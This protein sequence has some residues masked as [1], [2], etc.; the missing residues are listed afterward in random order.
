[1]A[2]RFKPVTALPAGN[3][4]VPSG[5]QFVSL[6]QT[7][8]N[9]AMDGILVI[10]KPQGMSSHD[11][12]GSLRRKYGQK[13]FG[14]CGT[15]DPMASGVLVV[16]AGKAA[17]A[18]Q[19]I[20]DTDKEYTAG[21][22]L[23]KKYDTDDI[24][25]SLLEEKTVKNDFDFEAVLS[26]FQGQLHQ[27]VPD[28]SAK[29]VNGKK[30]YEYLREGKQVPAVYSD[31]EIYSIE[32]LENSG[33]NS[34]GQ[35]PENAHEYKFHVHCSSGTYI[36]ALCRDFGEKTG[37]LAAMSSLCRTKANGFSIEQAE[38]LDAP[39]HT[40]YPLAAVIDLPRLQAE[41]PDDIRNGKHIRLDT[42]YDRVLIMEKD[43][44]LAVYDRHHGN[45]FSCTRGLW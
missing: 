30:L 41:N 23:G 10:N 5:L 14:H 4:T 36:R 1:M 2:C 38:P 17:R 39:V 19:F 24:W 3:R 35:Q 40:L 28:A 26:Q 15:L 7:I 29:K 43:E 20:S 9:G 33:I 6:L 22:V 42:D 44:V 34:D 16:L 32:P 31:V 13:K 45:V 25:G 8:Y 11:V 21:L 37:N 27:R 12:I 18:L